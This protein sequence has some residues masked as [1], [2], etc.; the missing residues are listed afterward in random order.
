MNTTKLPTEDELNQIF[1][2]FRKQSS[3]QSNPDDVMLMDYRQEYLYSKLWLKIRKR[4]LKR[5]NQICAFCEG[6]ANIVHHRSYERDVLEGKADQMLVSL[7]SVCHEY[8]H[9]DNKGLRRS[10]EES[11][12]ILLEKNPP[13]DIPE[14]KLRKN[15]LKLPPEWSGMNG[16]QKKAWMARYSELS[17]ER[18]IALKK[19][20]ASAHLL[21]KNAP[22]KI[23][24]R[25]W[26]PLRTAVEQ[27]RSEE[28]A[29]QNAYGWYRDSA[30]R[31]G[32]VS[33]AGCSVS[34]EK[35][36]NIWCVDAH[37]FANSI[38]IHRAANNIS[39][40]MTDD[41]K[42]GVFHVSDGVKIKT[43]WGYYINRGE[44][45]YSRVTT[46]FVVGERQAG[47]WYCDSCNIEAYENENKHEIYCQK[48]GKVQSIL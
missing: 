4:I 27:Y 42:N 26:V 46:M 34:A 25:I 8:I 11:D 19:K 39:K 9:F 3:R 41:Y 31:R 38:T 48:C 40:E 45:R 32:C 36:K 24:N 23:D 14:P 6:S 44:F 30:M 21:R 1:E 10:L 12:Q 20:S 5:D 35:V 28:R 33:I 29:I 15:C 47:A 37:E 43:E 2:E 16:I 18:C 7:C 13:T 17:E 22:L